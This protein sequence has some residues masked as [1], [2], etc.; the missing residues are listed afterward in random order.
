M[1]HMRKDPLNPSTYIEFDYALCFLR[2]CSGSASSLFR[3]ALDPKVAVTTLNFLALA[4]RFKMGTN[5]ALDTPSSSISVCSFFPAYFPCN[6]LS[7]DSFFARLFGI[8][9]LHWE[10]CRLP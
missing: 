8:M 3:F 4:I 9:P 6:R 1:I 5:S 10:Y 7:K 2:S